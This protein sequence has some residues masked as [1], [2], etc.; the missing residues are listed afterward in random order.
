MNALVDSL[1]LDVPLVQAPM[2][3]VSTPA[4]AAAVSNAGALGSVAIGTL[5]PAAARELIGAVASGTDRA[6][7]VNVFAHAPALPDGAR[8]RAWLERLEPLFAEFD[9]APPATIAPAYNSFLDDDGMLQILL[10]ARPPVVS[11]HF[12]LPGPAAVDALHARGCCLLA[13]ATSLAEARRVAAAGLDAVVLQGVQAGGHRGTFDPAAGDAGM[14]T[15][16]LVRVAADELQLPLIA[17]GGLMDG[18]DVHAVLAAGASAAQLGTAF[19]ACPESSASARH[20][21]LVGGHRPLATAITAAISGRPARGIHNRF[22]AD[23]DAAGVAG[24]PQAYVAARALAAAAAAA[25]SEAFDIMWAGTGA[26]RARALPAAAVVAQ[27]GA[28]LVAAGSA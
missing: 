6:F 15:L 13:S 23:V 19:I 20:K 3:G 22:F 17:A 12:G 27:I 8:E 25:G 7:N 24:Y 11:F 28:E 14:L 16:D 21:R 10:D 9:A 4:L 5:A 18:R 26:G 1:G 2:A